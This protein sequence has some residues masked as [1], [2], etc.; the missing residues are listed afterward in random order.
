MSKRKLTSDEID[1]IEDLRDLQKLIKK[2]KL[3]WIQKVRDNQ[4]FD[5]EL[6][7]STDI[8]EN[9]PENFV[10]CTVNN[11]KDPKKFLSIEERV[12][13]YRQ[14][15]SWYK[16]GVLHGHTLDKKAQ[17]KLNA[18]F[19]E[20]KK[21]LKTDDRVDIKGDL[22][23][24]GYAT[25]KLPRIMDVYD[26]DD[27]GNIQHSYIVISRC[28]IQKSIKCISEIAILIAEYTWDQYECIDA[29]R[30][31]SNEEDAEEWKAENHYR[32]NQC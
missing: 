24:I 5:K 9:D 2:C 18:K 7:L 4:G 21:D 1:G 32:W 25:M 22:S 28:L 29:W 3:K 13:S 12:I 11:K 26:E 20:I 8:L 30:F 10:I 19:K 27:S 31:P 6:E 15:C 14:A 23:N 16:Y 17:D